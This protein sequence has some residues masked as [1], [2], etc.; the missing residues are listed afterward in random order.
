MPPPDAARSKDEIERAD[1]DQQADEENDQD[2]PAEHLEHERVLL[3]MR[4]SVYARE[5]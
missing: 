2:D 3:S 1:H 4:E 5:G